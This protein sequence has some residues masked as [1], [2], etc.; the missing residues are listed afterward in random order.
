MHWIDI[1][2]IVIYLSLIFSV[3]ILM[4]NRINNFSSFMIAGQGLGLSLG[5]TSM[6][7]TELGLITVMYNAQTG[8]LQY[9]SAFHIGL[10]AFIVTLAVGL[11]GFVVTKLRDMNVK[12][13][14]EFYGK[15]FG[16]KARI[17]GAFLLVIGGT[18]NMGIFL[19]VGAKFVQ[20]IFGFEGSDQILK[21][22]MIILLIIVLIYTMMG[23]ML[24]V[25][26]TD[27]FQFIVLSI[28][29]IFCVFYSILILG[30]SNIFDSV[31]KISSTP[32]NPFESKG[33]SYVV[34]QI[35][36]AFVSAVVWPT[37]ITRALTM[38]DSQTVKKQY[39]WSSI[40]FLIR[41]MI[42]CFIGIC[43]VVYYNVDPLLEDNTL[44]LMPRYLA[45]I[46]PIGL[47]GLIT[48]GMLSAFMSTHDSYLLCWSTII[49]N[50][51]I[52]PLYGNKISSKNKINISRLIIVIL[53]LYILYWGLF[54]EG[55]DSIWSYIGIT[56]AIYFSGAITILIGG[57][58]WE[59]A[60]ETGA[61]LALIGGLSALI[62]LEPIREYFSIN[63][64]PEQ[65]GLLSIA[66]TSYL[67][68]FGSFI[69]PRN[70]NVFCTKNNKGI[71]Q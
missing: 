58:Y 20:S 26:V 18:L 70:C 42:P 62:G 1:S 29:L 52:E 16:Q 7:G 53:G 23:G 57:L 32:Y 2:I 13:I 11:S 35:I 30:W 4:R 19:N 28:G 45:D 14:P 51:I 22:I 67:F 69:F 49:T 54:Y 55:S 12:S 64:I 15:R 68:F 5:V 44:S 33:S 60:S 41:F 48:A 40:S 27:Y 43:A 31:E 6:L 24:S 21:I 61:I 56:G 34:W 17:T 9:F 59:K 46:L 39:V 71:I 47:L 38:K 66:L 36:L 65:I 8:T 25:V 50:D 37:A 3:G 10:F 63:L